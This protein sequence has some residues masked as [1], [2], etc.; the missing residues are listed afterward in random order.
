LALHSDTNDSDH[1]HEEE[2]ED[3]DDDE[4]M[5]MKSKIS[6]VFTSF[7]STDRDII[8]Q[9]L[10]SS[11]LLSTTAISS[12][13]TNW[14]HGTYDNTHHDTSLLQSS[15]NNIRLLEEILAMDIKK[16]EKQWKILKKYSE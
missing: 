8:F 13:E 12:L 7:L 6:Q 10:N 2:E 3:D 4:E 11:S 1:D 16:L 14:K 5:T 9:Q 15:R